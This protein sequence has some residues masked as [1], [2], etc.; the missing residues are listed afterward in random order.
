MAQGELVGLAHVDRLCPELEPGDRVLGS[1]RGQRPYRPS[2]AGPCFHSS[3]EDPAE[4][5]VPNQE[6]LVEHEVQGHPV[7][8]EQQRRVRRHQPAEPRGER[9]PEPD[10]ER[11]RDVPSRIRLHRPDVDDEPSPGLGRR[12]RC[13]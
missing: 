9:V 1:D 3:V 2:L 12:E 13:G 11:P 6:R 4:A 5:L 8:D 10:R 7:G